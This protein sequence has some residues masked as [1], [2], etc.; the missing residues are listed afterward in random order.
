MLPFS[1]WCHTNAFQLCSHVK[2]L[3]DK[4]VVHFASLMKKSRPGSHL[5]GLEFL[6]FPDKTLCTVETVSKYLSVTQPMRQSDKSLV[7]LFNTHGKPHK[8]ASTD[9]IAR[10]IKSTPYKAGVPAEFTAHSTWSAS[11][12]A[13]VRR[14]IDISAIVHRGLT[15]GWGISS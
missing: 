6:R 12:S 8:N 13:D 7:S 5:S 3:D 14:G 10:W 15:K 4:L 1:L 9:T 2:V 11:T